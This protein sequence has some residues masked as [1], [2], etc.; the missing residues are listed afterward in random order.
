MFFE[1]NLGLCL[2]LKTWLFEL[3]EFVWYL[4]R[5]VPIV[6]DEPFLILTLHEWLLVGLLKHELALGLRM[7]DRGLTALIRTTLNY[8]RL[9]LLAVTRVWLKLLLT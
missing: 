7:T 6:R 1:G 8:L 2:V 5:L 4:V 3:S 9:M